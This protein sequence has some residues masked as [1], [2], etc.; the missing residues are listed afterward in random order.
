MS[1]IAVQ[2]GELGTGTA[3]RKKRFSFIIALSF[4][5]VAAVLVMAIFG[6]L[7]APYDPGE[8]D[9]SISLAKPSTDHWFGTDTLG[10][11]V[12]SRVIAGARTAV[13]GPAVISTGAMLFGCLLGLL[14]GYRGRWVDASIMRWVDL[15]FALPGLLVLIVVVGAFG[16]GYWLGI[17]ILLILVIPGETRIVRGVALEQTPRPYVEAAKTLGVSDK[18]IMLVHIWPNIS[19]TVL[20][21]FFLTFA[22]ILV[23]LSGLSFLGLGVAPGTPDWGLMLAE[24]RLL[25]FANPVGTLAPGGMIVLTA[26]ATNLIGDWLYER[27][28]SRGATR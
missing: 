25:L 28:A 2:A 1:E 15:M 24:S 18:R 22:A 6:A 12:F 3:V 17:A 5:V 26:T 19:A 20:A 4:L 9:L 10:R 16:G 8:Q 27:L 11:D 23:G 7:I 14:A 21:Q 13:I